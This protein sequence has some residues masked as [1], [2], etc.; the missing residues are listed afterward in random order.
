MIVVYILNHC[1]TIRLNS[2][3]S[4]EAWTGVKPFVK[5]LKIFGSPCYKHIQ[6]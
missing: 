5:N 4:E 6:D 3:V 1:P 2:M